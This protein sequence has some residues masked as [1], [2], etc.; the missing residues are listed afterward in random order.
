M[1][2]VAFG[3]FPTSAQLHHASEEAWQ[4]RWLQAG[5]VC[6]VLFVSALVAV[7]SRKHCCRRADQ[8]KRGPHLFGLY[9]A[10]D[11]R[12]A[13][14]HTLLLTAIYLAAV[15]SGCT[16]RVGRKSGLNLEI[17]VAVFFEAVLTTSIRAFL[18]SSEMSPS[19]VFLAVVPF[20]A[21]FDLLRDATL[22]GA[23]V[24]VGSAWTI[25][26]ASGIICSTLLAKLVSY[27]DRA[28]CLDVRRCFWAE[29]ER[30]PP[31]LE[32][33]LDK[34]LLRSLQGEDERAE[35]SNCMYVEVRNESSEDEAL[36]ADSPTLTAD[37]EHSET[38]QALL[39]RKLLVFMAESTSHAKQLK[40]L[41]EQIPQATIGTAVSLTMK[42]PSLLVFL[43]VLTTWLQVATIYMVRPFVL[44][45]EAA[46]GLAW[47]N[48]SLRDFSRARECCWWRP[49]VGSAAL[50]C[51]ALDEESSLE[52]RSGAAAALCEEVEAEQSQGLK[53][54]EAAVF[55]RLVVQEGSEDIIEALAQGP[56]SDDAELSV[57]PGK[58]KKWR[59]L[60]AILART[61]QAH[62]NF[63]QITP[64]ILEKELLW[65]LEK[66]DLPL[67][68]LN[69]NDNK[70]LCKTE[71][72]IKQVLELLRR[73]PK[74]ERLRLQRTGISENAEG[75]ARL[76]QAW[77]P[78]RE[79][80]LLELEE[81][82]K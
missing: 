12:F 67:K 33:T 57:A 1:T 28:D 50:A 51:V 63:M 68:Y 23:F 79:A 73:C 56:I 55:K 38:A 61:S 75:K 59:L 4:Q 52:L 58:A 7:A 39:L 16:G 18:T 65:R 9:T 11:M 30:P 34:D 31:R 21:R 19:K 49:A 8:A 77:G 72:G 42:A 78:Q 41:Y 80:K 64:E 71:A 48:T 40:G 69:L 29:G 62:V 15:F 44:C 37:V 36:A 20:S 22:V 54:L 26:G 14:Y 81:E 47:V 43:C 2:S 66:E 13:T 76:R 6:L 10:D 17:W 27:G 46:K 35:S 60:A 70:E 24:Q 74:L 45:M 53:N 32:D 5:S 82:R 3:T 25:L